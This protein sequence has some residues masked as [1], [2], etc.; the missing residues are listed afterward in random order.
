MSLAPRLNRRE[1]QCVDETDNR[2]FGALLLERR[3]VDLLCFRQDL[4]TL[5]RL[6]QILE[7]R[8]A[9]SARACPPAFRNTRLIASRTAVSDV[10][11]RFD[12]QARHE[13]D[14]VHGEHVRR[15]RHRQRERV[16]FRPTG[17]NS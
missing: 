12:V 3:R 15:I 4:Q 17:M 14:V 8:V 9:R 2:R 11:D 7:R 13:L 5:V 6:P 10:D 16:P 1:Q